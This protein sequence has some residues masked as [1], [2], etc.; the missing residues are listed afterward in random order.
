MV[1]ALG[2][3]RSPLGQVEPKL[4]PSGPL[5]SQPHLQSPRAC[6]SAAFSHQSPSQWVPLQ[7]EV[8]N[9]SAFPVSPERRVAK[10]SSPGHHI[11]G[12]CRALE[13]LPLPAFPVV[14][15]GVGR[16]VSLCSVLTRGPGGDINV[17]PSREPVPFRGASQDAIVCGR[18]VSSGHEAHPCCVECDVK[19]VQEKFLYFLST[20]FVFQKCC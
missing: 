1:R 15:E 6:V 18:C 19:F 14:A 3:A 8:L 17:K 16:P 10:L 11:K 5:C 2:A 12:V 4:W 9:P 13:S 7:L 20:A